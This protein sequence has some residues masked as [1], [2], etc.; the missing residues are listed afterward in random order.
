MKT[1]GAWSKEDKPRVR[2]QIHKDCNQLSGTSPCIRCAS[3]TTLVNHQYLPIC[4]CLVCLSAAAWLRYESLH[5]K[6]SGQTPGRTTPARWCPPDRRS[7]Q[8]WCLPL[9]RW[10]VTWAQEVEPVVWQLEGCC[11]SVWRRGVPDAFLTL[12][13]P[14][15]L[16]GGVRG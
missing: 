4:K 6:V 9:T 1:S 3:I 12:T 13:S 2:I 15:L 10:Y 16:A 8:A 14:D 5:V 7:L 11:L